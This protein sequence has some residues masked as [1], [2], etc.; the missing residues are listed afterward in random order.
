MTK[1]NKL[2]A[3]TIYNMNFENLITIFRHEGNFIFKQALSPKFLPFLGIF[4]DNN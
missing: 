3:N 4:D 1:S 2:T